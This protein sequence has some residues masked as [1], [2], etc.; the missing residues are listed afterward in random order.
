MRDVLS[1]EGTG[2]EKKD[3]QQVLRGATSGGTCAL[4]RVH[5]V[6]HVTTHHCCTRGWCTYH[7]YTWYYTLP[8]ITVACTAQA[9]TAQVDTAQADRAQCGKAVITM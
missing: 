1:K 8:G 4:S 6:L 9:D 7:V 3:P 2:S 5:V